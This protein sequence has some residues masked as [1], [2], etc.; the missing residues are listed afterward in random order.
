MD[1]FTNSQSKAINDQGTEITLF[2]AFD[3]V[4]ICYGCAIFFVFVGKFKFLFF[5]IFVFFV[6][7]FLLAFARFFVFFANF[8]GS[9]LCLVL[10]GLCWQYG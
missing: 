8:S 3:S 5:C 7:V 4:L 2:Y 10:M 1:P 6:V 9:K